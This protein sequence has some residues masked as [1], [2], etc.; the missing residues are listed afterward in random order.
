MLEARTEKEVHKFYA[1]WGPK[2][3]GFCRLLLGDDAQA[4]KAMEQGFLD[5]VTRDLEVDCDGMPT[6]LFTFALDAARKSWSSNGEAPVKTNQ[7]NQAILSLPIA[8]RAV[9][10][11]RSVMGLDEEVVGEIVEIPFQDVRKRWMGSLRHIRT[12][13]SEDFFKERNK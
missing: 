5:Y 6:L 4:E 8:E 13:L 12:L 2:L 10:I 11:L 7:L 9:F 3:C 1:K